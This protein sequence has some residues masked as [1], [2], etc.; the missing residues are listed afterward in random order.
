MVYNI[1]TVLPTVNT[2]MDQ[3]VHDYA[4]VQQSQYREI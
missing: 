2:K 3:Y 1:R 4:D